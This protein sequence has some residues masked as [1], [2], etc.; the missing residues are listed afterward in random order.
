MSYIL[1][2]DDLPF[3]GDEIIKT[4]LNGV[5]ILLF[6]F[7]SGKTLSISIHNKT[8]EN[9]E[10]CL[11][12]YLNIKYKDFILNKK[13]I[14]WNQFDYICEKCKNFD[15]MIKLKSILNVE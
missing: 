2:R 10:Q 5:N 14:S 12:Y 9:F 4:E 7:K 1:N 11:E 8:P 13:Q 6:H 3:E 15:R